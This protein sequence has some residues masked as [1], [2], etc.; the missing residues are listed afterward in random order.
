M[1][2]ILDR[3]SVEAALQDPCARLSVQ[4]VYSRSP[5]LGKISVLFT[6]SLQK[7]FTRGLVATSRYKLSKKEFPGEISIGDLLARS[8]EETS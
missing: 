2:D 8:L 4:D 3:F 1:Q 5:P 7:I 6:R